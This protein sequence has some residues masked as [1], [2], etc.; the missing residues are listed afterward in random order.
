MSQV[1]IACPKCGTQFELT[2]ALK[3]A[4]TAPLIEAEQKKMAADLDRQLAVQRKAIADKAAEAVAMQFAEK[5]KAAE[6]SAAE[7][8]AKLCEAQEAEL[9]ARRAR[10]EVEQAK[11]TIELDVR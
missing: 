11:R 4:L 6:A 3:D 10:E 1:E 2:E 5:L 8:D 9:A 7:K